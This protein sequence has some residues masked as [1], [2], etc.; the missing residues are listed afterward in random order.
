MHEQADNAALIMWCCS[1]PLRP[2]LAES[3][4]YIYQATGDPLWLDF[5][6]AMVF[7]LQNITKVVRI[8]ENGAA[9]KRFNSFFRT[10]VMLEWQT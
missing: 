5:G 6:K 1:Y 8:E 2:E 7:T 3:L 10:V 4:Y 9:S